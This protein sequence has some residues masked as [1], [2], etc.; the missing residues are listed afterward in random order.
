MLLN[1]LD[2]GIL[3]VFFIISL[4][5]GLYTS[6]SNQSAEDY[7]VGGGKMPWWLLGVSMVATTFSTDTPNLVTD[8]VRQN[9]I[10]G[11]W[12]WWAFLLTGML[13]VFV[14]AGLW[15]KAKILTDIEFY[16][17][18][19][20]GTGA[21]VLRGFRAVYLGLFFNVMIMATV[22]L[23]AI[24]IGGVLLGLSPVQTILIAGIV[25][26]IY[27]MFG[28]LKGVL[29]TDFIQ[30]FIAMLG[31]VLAAWYSI[32]HP[33]VGGMDN[34]LANPNVASKLDFFPSMDNWNQF[35]AILLIPVLVQ[36]W[37]VWYPGAEPGG[38]GY[39]VQRMFAAKDEN[40][41]IKSVLFF[42]VAHYA[43]RPWPWIIVALCSLVVFP[44]LESIKQAFPNAASIVKDDLAYSAMLTFLP[45]GVLGL[46]VT[47]LIAAYMS[48]IS[49]HLNW[50][51]SYLV[52]DVYKR[53]INPTASEKKLLIVGQ[54]CTVVLMILAMFIALQLEN[55]YQSFEI[56]L[57][58]GAG[59]G[60]LFILRWF[61]WRINAASEI[62][63][64]ISSFA[65]AIYFFKSDNPI[66]SDSN[67][68]LVLS[69]ALTTFVWIITALVTKPTDEKVL[70]NFV[71]SV[72]P[73]GPGWKH[74]QDKIDLKGGSKVSGE[75]WKVPYGMLC[76]IL[77]VLMVY[78][79]LFGTG[80]IIFKNVEMG[81]IYLIVSLISAFVLNK[82]YKKIIN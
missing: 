67:D 37:S 73:R 66:V 69:V 33:M 32:N 30:F 13:T 42:N 61:W 21:T 56:L 52:L 65:I 78:S 39:I 71:K 7:F 15:K 14:Y 53:F 59:T 2:W 18:R 40:N 24:K 16:E 4:A 6:K 51:S 26:V 9:G 72:Q 41:A 36:W 3:V 70:K 46:V 57:K 62:A 45:H 12:T 20:S 81:L 64:M 8:I 19:Y 77:G 22:S 63:A 80:H 23:A 5:I 29:L 10:A 17:K 68:Q 49:T 34:L 58:I 60:L 50:G 35:Y 55:A 27:S 43:L 82:Y 25:T 38:G 48:T 1:T 76:M 44:D 28:G 79:F 75:D 54:I 47:S 11:N 74:I 31:S